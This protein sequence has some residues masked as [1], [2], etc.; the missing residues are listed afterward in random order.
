MK[1]TILKILVFI[2]FQIT[3][4][5]S[6]SFCIELKSFNRNDSLKIIHLSFSRYNTK[7]LLRQCSRS[8]PKYDETFYPPLKQVR[9]CLK[10]LQLDNSII[11]SLRAPLS[12]YHFQIVGFYYNGNKY[13]YLNCFKKHFYKLYLFRKRPLMVCD[14]GPNF[15]GIVYDIEKN[16]FKDISYN[17]IG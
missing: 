8:T 1:S 3:L 11:K 6:D 2:F 9:N 16:V 17:G 10:H 7:K 12:D 4:S 5:C 13:L 14:G 15:W